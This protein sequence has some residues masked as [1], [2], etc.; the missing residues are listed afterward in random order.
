[1][2]KEIIWIVEHVFFCVAIVQIFVSSV[3]C[4]YG[5]KWRKGLIATMSVYVGLLLGMLIAFPLFKGGK[6]ESSILVVA[7]VT[8]VFY[9]S[10]YKVILLNHFLAG[11]L[12]T[13]KISYMVI[14]ALME[15]DIV[16]ANTKVL[17]V[18]PIIIG[19][20]SGAIILLLY[21]NNIV[22][23]CLSFI[24]AVEIGS[25]AVDIYN[26]TMFTFTKDLSFIFDPI[27]YVLGLF[28]IDCIDIKE[29]VL[30]LILFI[31]SFFWQKYVCAKKGIDLTDKPMDDR[32]NYSR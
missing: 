29:V 17:I 14:F 30:I 20:L 23:L 25:K 10:A 31:I 24:G 32:K 2:T 22:I 12:L 5:Y 19:L 27:E 21:N 16:N 9:Y 13:V 1:M 4:I 6:V 7:V 11:F 8:I 28:G 3:M 15:N 26:K 18:F